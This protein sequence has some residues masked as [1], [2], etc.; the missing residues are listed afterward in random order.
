MPFIVAAIA[1]ELAGGISLRVGDRVACVQKNAGPEEEPAQTATT[2][3][4]VELLVGVQAEAGAASRGR[5]AGRAR[6]A[7]PS[8]PP[9]S[10]PSRTASASTDSFLSRPLI[11]AS[12]TREANSRIARSASSFPGT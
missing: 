10:C 9:S 5:R 4:V 3:D 2:G 1:G 8:D 11:T 7:P 12:A 6:C